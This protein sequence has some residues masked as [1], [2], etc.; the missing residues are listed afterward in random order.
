MDAS[1][2]V[3]LLDF[4]EQNGLEV[5]VDGGWAVDALL[6]KQ[7]RDHDDLDVAIPHAHVPLLRRL[8]ATRGFHERPQADSWKCN[9]VLADA[10]DRRLDVHS[11]TLDAAGKNVS[12]VPYAAEHL[13]GTGIIAGRPVRCI[14]PAWLVKFHTG[15]EGDERDHQDVRLLCERFGLPL[16]GE[17]LKFSR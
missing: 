7:T 10:G 16:P 13:T 6:G 1:D 3:E 14:D 5:Y 4:L 8:M 17:Y 12:G 9:F 15:Y 11:Y 2:V